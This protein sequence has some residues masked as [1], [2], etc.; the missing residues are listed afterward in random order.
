MKKLI[1]A[2]VALTAAITFTSCEKPTTESGFHNQIQGT[3]K[4]ESGRFAHMDQWMDFLQDDQSNPPVMITETHINGGL[5]TA[6][7]YEVVCN[8]VINLPSDS[9]GSPTHVSVDLKKKKEML[10]V[11]WNDQENKN[12]SLVMVF[13]YK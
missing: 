6:Q 4:M 3:W 12:D 1:F 5:W 7:E 11:A 9:T 10:W 13:M 8:G 2:L